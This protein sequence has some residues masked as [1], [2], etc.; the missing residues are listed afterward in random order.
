VNTEA[1]FVQRGENSLIVKGDTSCAKH[2]KGLP[3]RGGDFPTIAGAM[4]LPQKS[5][6][7]A[8]CI[9][10]D[11]NAFVIKSQRP[12]KALQKSTG[13][14]WCLKNHVAK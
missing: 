8:P 6:P 12:T 2:D 10:R 13:K 7:H 9:Y 14:I 11:E 1:D 5:F 4:W 3:F